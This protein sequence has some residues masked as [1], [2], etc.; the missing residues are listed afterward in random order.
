MLVAA[1]SIPYRTPVDQ[2]WTTERTLNALSDGQ[3]ASWTS[4]C[5]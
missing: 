5:L 3:L 4:H 1:W 2:M